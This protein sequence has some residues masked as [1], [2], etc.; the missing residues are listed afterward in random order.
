M[1]AWRWVVAVVVLGPS[2]GAETLSRAQ[3]VEEALRANPE[4][5]KGQE[6]A[7]RLRGMVVEA[8]ADALPEVSLSGS[9]LRY[10]DPSLLNSSSFDAFPPELRSSLAPIPASLWDA[11]V[12]LKQTLFSFKVGR[13]IKAARL[14]AA[15]GEEEIRRSRQDVALEA[16]RAY[17]RYLLALEQARVAEK[18]V[19]Q[20]EQHLEMARTRRAAGVATELDVLRSQVDLE[21]Q[22]VGLLRVQGQADLARGALNA[23]MVRP[24]DAAVEPADTLQYVPF[25]VTLEEA[26]REALANRP[27]AAEALLA[28]RINDHLVGIAAAEGLPSLELNGGY[29]WSVRETGNFLRQDYTK[30]NLAVSLKVPVFDGMRTSGRVAQ[31]RA[32]R[33]K[34]TQDRIALETRIRLEAKD[35]FDVL[36]VAASVVEAAQLNVE[37]A[38][39]AADMT[40]ANY[41]HGAA[42]TLDVLDAQAALTLA[43]S[44]LV[45]GLHAHSAARARLRYVM[46]RDP[47]DGPPA[48][49]ALATGTR[50]DGEGTEGSK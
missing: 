37:Q 21:N 27:E 38:R 29:G 46:G 50:M 4:V 41:R 10:R 8:R 45:E 31:A 39:R 33:A 44:N 48:A 47:L 19:R 43:E 34:A 14:G 2:A 42:T 6:E 25:A 12:S 9:G 16:V 49:A 17:D 7:A 22:R 1:K 5:H 28:E 24:I 11:G 23:V 18:A 30:W 36:R 26:V 3:A 32:E 15:Y 35:A 40:Q 20:K 13:A